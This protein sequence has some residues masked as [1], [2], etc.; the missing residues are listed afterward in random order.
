MANFR[1]HHLLFQFFLMLHAFESPKIKEDE[2]YHFLIF[3]IKFWS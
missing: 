1:S 3:K 2:E